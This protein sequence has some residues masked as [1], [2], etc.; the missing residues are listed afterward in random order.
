MMLHIK[1]LDIRHG[2]DAPCVVNEL[3]EYYSMQCSKETI[4]SEAARIP[5]PSIP[6]SRKIYWLNFHQFP[7]VLMSEDW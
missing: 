2:Y 7:S 4:E 3:P 6:Q 5:I 1:G